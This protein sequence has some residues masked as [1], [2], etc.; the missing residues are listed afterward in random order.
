IRIMFYYPNRAQAIRI[1]ETLKTVYLGVDGKYYFGDE[2]WDYVKNK[3]GV[4]LLKILQK[5]AKIKCLI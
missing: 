1:Q 3:T 4:E 5:I 2:A